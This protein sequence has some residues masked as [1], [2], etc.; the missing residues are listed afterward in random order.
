MD[1]AADEAGA[2]KAEAEE[3]VEPAAPNPKDAADDAGAAGAA[4][5]E[6]RRNQSVIIVQHAPEHF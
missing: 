1:A 5:T 3:V 4:A 2:P 6:P